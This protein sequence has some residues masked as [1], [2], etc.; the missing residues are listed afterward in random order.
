MKAG[1]EVFNGKPMLST[2]ATDTASD[3]SIVEHPASAT[4]DSKTWTRISVE[5]GE[6]ELGRSLLVFAETAGGEDK[7]QLREICWAYSFPD[8]MTEIAVAAFAARP[9]KNTKGVLE[10]EFKDFEVVFA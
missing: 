6:D 3:W 1:I 8:T 9:A 10:V 2:V 7:I 5:A 4:A